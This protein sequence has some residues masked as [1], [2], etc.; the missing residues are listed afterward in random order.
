MAL[1]DLQLKNTK[2]SDKDIW[3]SDEKGLRAL[4]KATNGKIY[5]RLKYRFNN[6]QKTLALGVYP[7]T[8]LKQARDARDQARQLI[9]Q[10]LDPLMEKQ[11]A[12]Q[13]SLDKEKTTLSAVAKAWWKL[14]KG[15]WKPKHADRVWT[16]LNDNALKSLGNLPIADIRPKQVIQTTKNIEARG[17]F[18][19]ARRVLQDLRRVFRH[20]MINDII[21]NNPI[22]DVTAEVLKSKKS[23][24]RASLPHNELPQFL[25]LLDTYHTLLIHASPPLK[26]TVSENC[27]Y[28]CTCS[29]AITQA[30]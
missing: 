28:S 16:R 24:R 6:K 19:V 13:A 15:K 23:K 1:T 14:K 30:Q 26:Q 5:F 7:E 3:L 22:G 10:G 25:R 20:A 2:P 21:D 18:D 11:A 4:I 27:I 29:L 12:K 9:K 8:S 17:S